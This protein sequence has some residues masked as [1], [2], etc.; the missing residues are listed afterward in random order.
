MQIAPFS[1][2]VKVQIT[3]G[4]TG[5][6][7][8]MEVELHHEKSHLNTA[9][10]LTTLLSEFSAITDY[11]TL[12]D[13]LPRKLT[14]LLQCRGV[15]LYQ[16]IDETLQF[17]AGS[18][19][20]A[21]GWSAE[22]LA[23]AHINPIA[24][25][26]NHLEAR[27]WRERH[28]VMGSSDDSHLPAVAAPLLYR[29]RAVGVIIAFRDVAQPG[30]KT[31]PNWQPGEVALMDAV[32]GVVALLLEN[33]RLLEKDRERIHELALLNSIAS[34]LNSV[35]Y[36]RE[37]TLSIIIQ[38]TKE[39]TGAD[40]CELI[41]SDSDPDSA[42]T[43]WLPSA[44]SAMLLDRVRKQRDAQINPLI[45]ERPG[46]EQSAAYLNQLPEQIKT[47][48]A[49]PLLISENMLYSYGQGIG[50]I[51]G[52]AFGSPKEL[53]LERMPSAESAR[54]ATVQEV[55]DVRAP[56]VLGIIVGAYHHA[57]KLR[58]EERILLQVLASQASAVLENIHLMSEVIAARNQARTL[59]RQV[60]EDQ[61]LKE[62]ILES[63]PSG[64]ITFDLKGR[65]TTFNRAAG[66][67]LGY[68]PHEALGQ[69]LQSIFNTAVSLEMLDPENV[70]SHSIMP[71]ARKLDANMQI[72]MSE[73]RMTLERES[74]EIVLNFHLVPLRNDLHE[75]IGTLATFSDVTMMHH[76]EE[77]KRRLDRLATLGEM[78]ASVAHE[79]RNPLAS[80]KTSIQLLQSDLASGMD[81]QEETQESLLV[82][83]KEIERL[84]AIVRD[85]L[86]FSK[87]R[88]MHC[89]TYN[90]VE[91]SKQVLRMLQPQ[92]VEAGIEIHQV[93]HE[94]PAAFIDVAQIE[95][96]LL[97][98]FT[99]A[100]QAM[101][102]GGVLTITSRVITTPHETLTVQSP[103]EKSL[104]QF[105]QPIGNN[106]DQPGWIE[107]SV[108]DT[109]IGIAPGLLENIFQPFFTT[110]AHGIG[111]GLPISRRIIEDHQGYVLVES[112]PGY[113]TNI[114]IRLP[115]FTREL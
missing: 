27:A 57:W 98:L 61:R 74:G 14:S 78:A 97:N 55:V 17:A 7:G 110:K 94:I 91:L 19:D 32:S 92:C 20:D 11:R 3:F 35:M 96:V 90:L 101:P 12:R 24:L 53:L 22:L 8:K 21:P 47:F 99:N 75:R 89:V 108:G 79:V 82:V 95:Q 40:Q 76:L 38:R 18:F 1:A 68:H 33:T 72:P 73:T 36:E 105:D 64:L 81:T 111:L 63:V 9:E 54:R 52:I 84:D 71:S 23:V 67:I 88:H 103:D 46:N 69:P 49:V 66:A 50:K 59:L 87:E 13:S 85:L 5:D 28:A 100:I 26:G 10:I 51:G 2:I 112:Q 83:R 16:R 34:Q 80:I 39:I 4:V 104:L 41:I 42:V 56:K 115:L 45:I 30:N 86:L 107:L 109:G 114:S 93:Y 70:Q 31:F 113:G 48:F 60:L 58:R 43:S 15:L 25:T 65:I 6:Y 29:Q 37:R 106:G 77:E 102:D 62:L 44:L